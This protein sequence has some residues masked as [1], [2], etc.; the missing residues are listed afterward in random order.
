[1]RK[2]LQCPK[3]AAGN[4]LSYIDALIVEPTRLKRLRRQHKRLDDHPVAAAAAPSRELVSLEEQHSFRVYLCDA[5]GYSER[6]VNVP[7][8]VK[9]DEVKQRLG[10]RLESP[11][12]GGSYR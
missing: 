6:Y 9:D 10:L 11:P 4:V 8:I 7:D 1:M 5:C 12:S 3:C 2:T